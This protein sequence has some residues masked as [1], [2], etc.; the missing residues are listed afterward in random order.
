MNYI[1]EL[2]DFCDLYKFE[3]PFFQ[4]NTNGNCINYTVFWYNNRAYTSRYYIDDDESLKECVLFLANWVQNEKNFLKLINIHSI[5]Y[6]M[7]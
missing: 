5:D 2:K 3:F 7:T 4:Q 6:I 1:R